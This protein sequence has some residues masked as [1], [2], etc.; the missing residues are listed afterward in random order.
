MELK[1]FVPIFMSVLAASALAG[2]VPQSVKVEFLTV[3]LPRAAVGRRV[4]SEVTRRP[5][6]K[7][8]WLES[9][10]RAE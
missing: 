6:L 7:C 8:A 1:I 3:D 2:P 10:L 5:R 4:V 9:V